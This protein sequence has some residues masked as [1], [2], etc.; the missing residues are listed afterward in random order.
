MRDQLSP[1][2]TGSDYFMKRAGHLMFE[3]PV[4][5]C[6]FISASLTCAYLDIQHKKGHKKKKK[7]KLHN[8]YQT[9]LCNTH[10]LRMSSYHN[11]KATQ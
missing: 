9:Q 3:T 6:F 2:F 5:N 7:K 11:P 4:S 8:K 1:G 10:A